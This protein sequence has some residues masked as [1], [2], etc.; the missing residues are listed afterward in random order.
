MRFQARLIST[1]FNDG[2]GDNN[3]QVSE[4]ENDNE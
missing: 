4:N 3:K 1:A 2:T